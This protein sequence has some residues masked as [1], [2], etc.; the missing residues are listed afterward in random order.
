VFYCIISYSGD[1]L[2]DEFLLLF[3]AFLNGWLLKKL[4]AE[5]LPCHKRVKVNI[6]AEEEDK[7]KNV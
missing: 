7:M 3:F 1:V 5:K 6:V 4:S 2:A